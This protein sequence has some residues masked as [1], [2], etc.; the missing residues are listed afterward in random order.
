MG[1]WSIRVFLMGDAGPQRVDFEIRE[2]YKDE[3]WM[4]GMLELKTQN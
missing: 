2:G 4:P 1:Q 3:V